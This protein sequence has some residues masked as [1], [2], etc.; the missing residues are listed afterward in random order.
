MYITKLIFLL[1]GVTYGDI[2]IPKDQMGL[3]TETVPP[4]AEEVVIKLK[5]GATSDD[6]N[7][8]LNKHPEFVFDKQVQSL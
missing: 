8:I 2:S 4:P 7:D 6:L 3:N 1:L 5:P